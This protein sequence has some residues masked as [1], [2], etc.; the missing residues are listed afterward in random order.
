MIWTTAK[1]T[2]VSS[3]QTARPSRAGGFSPGARVLARVATGLAIGRLLAGSRGRGGG[4]LGGRVGAVQGVARGDASRLEAVPEVG[5]EIVEVLETDRDAEQPRGDAAL[6]QCRVVELAVG[7]RGRVDDHRE[8]APE[9]C[10]QLRQLERVDE[11][12]PGVATTGQ[13]EREHP[14]PGPQLA[15]GDVPLGVAGEGRMVDA[16]HASLTLQPARE[17]RRGRSMTIHPDRQR[18]E[19]AQ[20]EERR[21][22]CERGAGV[23]L[24]A[25]DRVDELA[26]AAHDAGEHV[27]VA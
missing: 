1:L 3:R 25:P 2:D 27:A 20:R 7:R 16:G 15:G 6:G 12:P 26:P 17:C 21:D 23:D 4:P 11:R 10:R 18:R 24:D 13:L 5:H 9:R 14:A 22:G 8:D 19:A